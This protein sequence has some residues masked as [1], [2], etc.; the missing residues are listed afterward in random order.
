MYVAPLEAAFTIPILLLP[1]AS[2]L[3]LEYLISLDGLKSAPERIVSSLSSMYL[4]YI[5]GY[6]LNQFFL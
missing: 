6:S 3:G 2:T 5:H 4:I 1:L